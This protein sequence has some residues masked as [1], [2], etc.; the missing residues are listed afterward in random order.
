MSIEIHEKIYPVTQRLPDTH[1]QRENV[2]RANLA[3]ASFSGALDAAVMVSPEHPI[4]DPLR[5]QEL[6]ESLRLEMLNTTLSLMGDQKLDSPQ[7]FSFSRRSLVFQSALE[8][9]RANQPVQ[10]LPPQELELSQPLPDAVEPTGGR[11]AALPPKHQWLEPIIA[12]ASKRYGI[13]AGL[14]KAVIKAESGFNPNAVSTAGA[15]GLMQLMPGTAKDLG[16]SNSFDP[17]QNI[18]AGTRFLRKLLN[19][20]DGDIDSTLAAYNWGPGNVDKNPDRL[21]RETRNYLVRVKQFYGG[22]AT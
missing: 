1:Q 11:S 9:Y 4:A 22:Y 7:S 12:K 15:R 17:E 19:R 10:T 14:I 20:Y 6:A 13:D 16:V 2:S 18:M 8:S 3:G 5:A 21:P